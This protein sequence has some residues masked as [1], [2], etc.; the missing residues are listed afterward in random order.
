MKHS[1]YF[2]HEVEADDRGD[3][4]DAN[5]CEAKVASPEGY[6][7]C[8]ADTGDDLAS[9][10]EWPSGR[11]QGSPQ[12][13]AGQDSE[14]AG[15]QDGYLSDNGQ[16]SS[17]NSYSFEELAL[18]PKISIA[19]MPLA[20]PIIFRHQEA[21]RSFWQ[22]DYAKVRRD[23]VQ[24]AGCKLPSQKVLRSG[25]LSVIA[26]NPDA[27]RRL[28]QMS[29]IAD[30]AVAAVLP[31]WYNKNMGKISGVPFRYTDRQLVDIFAEA[32]VIHARRQVTFLR[33]KDGSVSATPEDGIVLT[34]R[35]DIELPETIAL[36]FDEFRVHTYCAAPT[37]CYR[38]LRFGHIAHDCNSARRC[39]LCGG[40]HIY[41]DCKSPN[42]PVC[43]NC[44]GD[45][46][47]TFTGCPERRKVAM[48][49]RF[50][51]RYYDEGEDAS[52]DRRSSSQRRASRDERSSRGSASERK[53]CRNREESSRSDR[54]SPPDESESSKEDTRSFRRSRKRS[55][56]RRGCSR[57]RSP[58]VDSRSPRRENGTPSSSDDEY[59][60][61]SRNS[62]DTTEDGDNTAT[63]ARRYVSPQRE[64]LTPPSVIT[65]PRFSRDSRRRFKHGYHRYLHKLVKHGVPVFE[66]P[67][68]D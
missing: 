27:G 45:H 36:G 44:G 31:N 37:Q 21:S 59:R 23:L 14:S 63:P 42:E 54:G 35:P 64:R 65:F 33:R 3:H 19:A 26:P 13:S 10:E 7:R 38:C 48:A 12:R 1:D 24:C 11:K 30:I 25:F 62:G 18:Q 66:R 5:L 51:P 58:R 43:A 28:L 52:S 8:Q 60:G 67:L 17:C 2:D 15:Q 39:K 20:I 57:D 68:D 6:D 55:S 16:P 47:A 50:M 4:E 29:S 22:A 56:D 49:R 34:F 53:R 46:A 9:Q 40:P 61:G 32:G 41:K